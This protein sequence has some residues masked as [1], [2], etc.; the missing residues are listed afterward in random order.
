MKVTLFQ[1]SPASLL[2]NTPAGP[3]KVEPNVPVAMIMPGADAKLRIG[4]DLVTG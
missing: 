2:I 1:V 4:R 3:F